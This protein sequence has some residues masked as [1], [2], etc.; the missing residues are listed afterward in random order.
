MHFHLP[1]RHRRAL[2][3]PP[4]LLAL[5]GLLWLG[6]V[7]L[8]EQQRIVRWN[9]VQLTMPSLHAEDDYPNGPPNPLKWSDAK[10]NNFRNWREIKFVG[11]QSSNASAKKQLTQAVARMAANPSIEDGTKVTFGATATYS[12][13]IFVLDLM[14]QYDV[15]KYWLDVV[16]A[17]TTFYAITS[18]PLA[19][20]TLSDVSFPLGPCMVYEYH[21]LSLA[22]RYLSRSYLVRFDNWVTEL[23]NPKPIFEP[24]DYP[25]GP[26]YEEPIFRPEREYLSAV[27]RQWNMLLAPFRQPEWVV[28]PVLLLSLIVI[29]WQKLK[30]QISHR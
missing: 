22:P 6:C 5:A 2:L 29:S 12:D 14:N 30:R 19:K 17:P 20:K 1:R 3:F 28:F 13:L 10:L 4:G 25:Y 24:K 27:F 11:S 18:R 15:K 23:W 21:P 8:R 9:V 16:H 26:P 7:I